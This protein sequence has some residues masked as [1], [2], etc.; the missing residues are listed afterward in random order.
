MNVAPVML[1]RNVIGSLVGVGM[2]DNWPVTTLRFASRAEYAER[3]VVP[4]T[5]PRPGTVASTSIESADMRDAT[6]VTR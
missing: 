6:S 5:L 4:A 3:E 1:R 2:L